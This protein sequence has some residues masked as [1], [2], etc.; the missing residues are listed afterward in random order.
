MT[1]QLLRGLLHQE[2]IQERYRDGKR[3]CQ[4][5]LE[6]EGDIGRGQRVQHADAD[7]QMDQIERVADLGKEGEHARAVRRPPG[8]QAMEQRTGQCDVEEAGVFC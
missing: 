1:R 8:H 5:H 7:R 3:Q 4:R 2:E 6:A